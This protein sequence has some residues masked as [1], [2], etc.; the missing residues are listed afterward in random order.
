MPKEY[1]CDK[2]NKKFI[3]KNSFVRHFKRKT[4]CIKLVSIPIK[5]TELKTV[6]VNSG[7]GEEAKE[8]EVD[9]E[10]EKE[11]TILSPLRWKY[12]KA[13]TSLKQKE[14]QL[15]Y[16]TRMKSCKEILELVILDS[17]KFGII[18]E[19]IIQELFHISSRTSTQ[20]D[21]IRLGKK[22]EIKSARYWESKDECKWQHIELKYDY[23]LILF[24]LLDFDK[25]KVWAIKKSI[26]ISKE[27]QD[28]KILTPQ[29]EQGWW[30]CKTE[31]LPYLTP[32]E[33]IEELD[34]FIDSLDVPE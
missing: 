12:S 11:N 14:T 27:L 32:I 33:S 28:K 22:I 17:K 26:L 9:E 18:C 8:V 13:F 3:I 2:C 15:Q 23:D 19:K 5:H 29:G 25:F 7:A 6:T 30:V 20:N 1:E 16:Y 10:E 34:R 24:I 4:P 31:I 21:G